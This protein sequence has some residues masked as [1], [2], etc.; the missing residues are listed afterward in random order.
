[1]A[2]S[3]FPS[4]RRFVSFKMWKLLF[5]VVW[6]VAVTSDASPV[7]D[8]VRSLVKRGDNIRVCGRMLVDT[9]NMLCDGEYYDPSDEQSRLAIGKRSIAPVDSYHDWIAL[10]LRGASSNQERSQPPLQRY[11]RG[12]VDECC[13][14][15]CSTSTLVSYCSR[16]P[17]DIDRSLVSAGPTIDIG[18][19]FNG[20]PVNLNVGWMSN[21]YRLDIDKISPGYPENIGF[22]LVSLEHPEDIDRTSR[23]YR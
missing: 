21:W 7:L 16:Y 19:T 20:H 22:L 10:T 6:L 5:L 8:P 18:W 1:M 15:A 9:L 2:W 12:V 14:K 3:S 4:V 11:Q 23:R 17:E 13:R